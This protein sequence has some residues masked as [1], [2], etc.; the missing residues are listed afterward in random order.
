MRH[1][2]QKTSQFGQRRQSG[3]KIDRQTMAAKMTHSSRKTSHHL[4]IGQTEEKSMQENERDFVPVAAI[5]LFETVSGD[6]DDIPVEA[7]SKR[8][9]DKIQVTRQ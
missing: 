6:E 4:L 8:Q 2:S 1:S 9:K 7:L 5:L 3:T